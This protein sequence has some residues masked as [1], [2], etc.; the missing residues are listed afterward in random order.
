MVVVA[1]EVDVSARDE[2][3]GDTDVIDLPL[4]PP[5]AVIRGRVPTDDAVPN[6]VVRERTQPYRFSYAH[7]NVRVG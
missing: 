7:V 3:D 6:H 1:L 5:A 2:W 4:R